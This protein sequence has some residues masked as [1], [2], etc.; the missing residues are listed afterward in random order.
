MLSRLKAQAALLSLA[1]A[2]VVAPLAS[3]PALAADW[4]VRDRY[5]ERHV[6]RRPVTTR[7]VYRYSPPTRRVIVVDRP[8]HPRASLP[9]WRQPAFHV[10]WPPRRWHD[11]PRCWLPERHLCG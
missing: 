2:A 4:G 8:Y 7:I 3:A 11:R 9:R 5:V 1:A 10:G 6:V